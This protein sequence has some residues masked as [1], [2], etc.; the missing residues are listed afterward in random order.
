MTLVGNDEVEK[1]DVQLCEAVHHARIGR[2]VDTRGPID[3]VGFPDHA[4]WFA[5]QILFERVVSLNT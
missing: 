3:L 2:D 1:A 5:G 4:A